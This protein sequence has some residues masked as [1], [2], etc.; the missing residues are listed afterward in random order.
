MSTKLLIIRH[1]Q[2][3]ANRLGRW[4]GAT[5]SPLTRLGARQALCVADLLQREIG[6][7]DAIYSSPL[8]RC[9]R[10][11][12]CI[13][14]SL[15][16]TV[17]ADD[18]LRE[19]TIGELENTP[20]RLLHREHRFFE[21]ILEDP[22]YAPAGGESMKRVAVRTVAALER[23][24]NSHEDAEHI[25]VVSHGAAMAIALSTLLDGDL[26]RWTNYHIAN[27]SITELILKPAPQMGA[28]NRIEHL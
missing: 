14:Q 4:H 16:K 21:R 18:D 28:F 7:V 19:Y 23:I 11:A 9:Y 1:G 8:R 24:V 3:R 27:C 10:T 17:I 12:Q 20:Y 25:A 13:A 6:A 15:G 22:D 5:D 2:I 26:K